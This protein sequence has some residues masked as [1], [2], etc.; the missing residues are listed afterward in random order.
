MLANVSLILALLALGAHFAA[1]RVLLADR[2][3]SL[4][5]VVF[6]EQ[7]AKLVGND[8]ALRAVKLC[9]AVGERNPARSLALFLLGQ[10]LPATVWTGATTDYRAAP[11]TSPFAERIGR[12]ADEEVVRL[13]GALRPQAVA[14]IASGLVATAVA[15]AAYLV[16]Q[17]WGVAALVSGG[18]A[19]VGTLVSVSRVRKL[20][21]GPLA[22]RERLL[23]LLR[24]VEEM[25]DTARQAAQAVRDP[26]PSAETVTGSNARVW[27]GVAAVVGVGVPALVMLLVARSGGGG[28]TVPTSVAA[29]HVA[30]VDGAAPVAVG[31]ACEVV[32][33]YQESGRFNCHV[34]VQCGTD[35]L[36]GTE[37]G[38]GFTHCRFSGP[39]METALDDRW[40]EGDPMLRVD[41]ATR[42][43]KVRTE[44]WGVRLELDEPG[45]GP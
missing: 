29:A 15:G 26:V 2:T 37:D 43:V 41:R 42:S 17:S 31:A 10:E 19:V 30:E 22:V 18:L 21:A 24:P 3:S 27:V 25:S 28:S 45:P 9:R 4:S 44:K 13:L 1:V 14:A 38:M 33:T 20:R 36:Y 35:G 12:L 23:P 11:E 16:A 34:R 8:N 5:E 6:A 39:V 40:D 32:A 7:L